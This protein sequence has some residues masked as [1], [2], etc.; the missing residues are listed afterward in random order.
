MTLFLNAKDFYYRFEA[1]VN[2][3]STLKARR[4][5][6]SRFSVLGCISDEANA[7]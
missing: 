6:M 2:L 5:E 7:S 4:D 1:I 3:Q